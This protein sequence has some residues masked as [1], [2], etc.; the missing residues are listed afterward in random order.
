MQR[1]PKSR[2]RKRDNGTD[3]S[4][5]SSDLRAAFLDKCPASQYHMQIGRMPSEFMCEPE[6]NPAADKKWSQVWNPTC[7]LTL[8]WENR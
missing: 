1:K 4:E 8:W 7:G 2:P 5:V 3:G 6:S